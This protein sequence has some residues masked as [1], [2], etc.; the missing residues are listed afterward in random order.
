MWPK[1]E[2]RWGPHDIKEKGSFFNSIHHQSDNMR[3]MFTGCA[4]YT[5]SINIPHSWAFCF[6]S[7]WCNV[8]IRT[9]CLMK[10][11]YFTYQ[12]WIF[13]STLWLKYNLSKKKTKNPKKYII[14]LWFGYHEHCILLKY[15]HTHTQTLFS[16]PLLNLPL[17]CSCVILM[18][19]YWYKSLSSKNMC[20][21][22]WVGFG[23]CVSC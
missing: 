2:L 16:F 4:L 22:V 20:V 15:T 21:C 11:E 12:T 19:Y 18:K 8:K 1:C 13:C 7:F 23:V 14:I 10:W 6:Y 9:D 3:E 5:Y 17:H